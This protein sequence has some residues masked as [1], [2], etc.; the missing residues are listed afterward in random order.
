[1][2]AV[3][4]IKASFKVGA[5]LRGPARVVT[6]ER[7][8]WYDSA[9]LSAA[10]G[11]LAQVGANIHTDDDYAR[12]AGPDRGHRRRHD[13]DQLVLR[14]DGAP[15]RHGLS[16]RAASCAPSSSSPSTSTRPCTCAARCS[17]PSRTR[18][19]A[20]ST[21][22]TSGARTRT[23]S[24]SPTAAPRS[25]SAAADAMALLDA[26]VS[27]RGERPLRGR[28]RRTRGRGR[29]AA[30][31][32]RFRAGSG[33]HRLRRRLS[34]R[35]RQARSTAPASRSPRRG[36]SPRTRCPIAPGSRRCWRSSPRSSSSPRRSRSSASSC[37]CSAS[38]W[39]PSSLFGRDHK[40]VKLAGRARVQLRPPLP[41]RARPA[42]AAA[43]AS[44]EALASLGF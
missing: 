29:D 22:S 8:E 30:P 14:D 2:N 9:M 38:C 42:R 5:E 32:R 19:A 12:S 27:A 21:R 17:P 41:V 1:M 6:A 34:P 35:R 26:A 18:T 39:P 37:R 44:I 25:R 33:L 13:H 3:S 7:I 4:D 24:R 28:R 11:E 20:P 40:L 43:A 10:K 15:F 36:P 16:Q 31:A 23:A